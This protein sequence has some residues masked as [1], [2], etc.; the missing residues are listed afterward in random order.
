MKLPPFKN[1]RKEDYKD[2]PTWMASVFYIINNF[3]T[4]VSQGLRNG[5]TIRDNLDQQIFE[6]TFTYTTTFTVDITTTINH[7]PDGVLCLYCY[8][9][10]DRVPALAPS[11]AWSLINNGIRIEQLSG[12]TTGKQYTFRLLIV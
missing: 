11:L 9:E 2:A 4:S 7:R 8:N 6:Y 12:L 1:L 5:L 3:F 10:T